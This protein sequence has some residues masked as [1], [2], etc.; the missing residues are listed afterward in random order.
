MRLEP[1]LIRAIMLNVEGH[2][3]ADT[4]AWT[5]QQQLYHLA[6]LIQADLLKGA[7][8]LNHARNEELWPQVKERV[9]KAGGSLSIEVIGQ[10]LT[11]LAM[12][13]AGL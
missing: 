8:R 6:H 11:N 10:I 2:E 1:D 3:P 7:V 9:A 5:E 12:R 4:S 13:A